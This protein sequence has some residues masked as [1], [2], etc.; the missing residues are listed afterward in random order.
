MLIHRP[1]GGAVETMVACLC[2]DWCSTCRDYHA[3]LQD[4]AARHAGTAFAWVD[5]EEEGELTADL[6]IETFPTLL[7]TVRGD[8]RFFGPVLPGPET[9]GRLLR[10]LRDS[11]GQ[12]PIPVEAGIAALAGYLNSLIGVQS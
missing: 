7:V 1:A 12:P 4:Q 8:L 5:V 11:A 2:A 9:L 10:A 3:M 6:D